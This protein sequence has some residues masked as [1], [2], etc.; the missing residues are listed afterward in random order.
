MT[1]F[2][3]ACFSCFALRFSDVRSIVPMHLSTL[4]QSIQP[5]VYLLNRLGARIQVGD[6]ALGA[7][8]V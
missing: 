3:L 5:A 7:G 4:S 1:F 6:N 8:R 2:L